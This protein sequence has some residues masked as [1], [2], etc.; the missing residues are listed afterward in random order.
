MN[1]EQHIHDWFSTAQHEIDTATVL[2]EEGRAFNGL[3]SCHDCV[4]RML[5]GL[6]VM[7][8]KSHPPRTSNLLWLMK[9]LS[10]EPGE[11]HVILILDLMTFRRGSSWPDEIKALRKTVRIAAAEKYLEKTEDLIHWIKENCL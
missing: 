7:R 1:V 3:L 4:E 9:T 5:K 10:I 6:Y 11:D 2:V 8:K